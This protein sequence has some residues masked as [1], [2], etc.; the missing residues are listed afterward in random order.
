[1]SSERKIFTEIAECE[2]NSDRKIPASMYYVVKVRSDRED[3][4]ELLTSIGKKWLRKLDPPPLIL[5]VFRSE[6]YLLFSSR[7]EEEEHYA[8]GSH[9]AL[10]SKYSATLAR[11]K[12]P[13]TIRCSIV[14][15]ETR[16]QILTYFQYKVF[17]YTKVALGLA[18]EGQIS[19]ARVPLSEGLEM[20]ESTSPGQWDKLSDGDKYG[21]FYKYVDRRY[22]TLSEP[23]D[24]R[25]SARYLTFLFGV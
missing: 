12:I 4:C 9:Q 25:E 14:E 18:S 17:E 20:L 22:Q 15:F 2:E 11:K 6:A 10:C 1:M 21:T 23:I 24:I 7:D 5:Y 3:S 19:C 8:K 16:T 13:G